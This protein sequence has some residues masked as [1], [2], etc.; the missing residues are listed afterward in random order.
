MK[1]KFGTEI[2]TIED[3]WKNDETDIVYCKARAGKINVEFTVED[4]KRIHNSEA[5][6]GL[7]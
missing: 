2:K 3:Y 7:D 5:T 1:D 6:Y 4:M